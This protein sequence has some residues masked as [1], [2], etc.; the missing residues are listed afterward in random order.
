MTRKLIVDMAHVTEKKI[1]FVNFDL[2]F[3][4]QEFWLLL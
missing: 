4:Y 3:P 2:S 1:V